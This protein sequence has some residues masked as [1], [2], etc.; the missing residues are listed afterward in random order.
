[1]P[2]S[3][4]GARDIKAAGD[5]VASGGVPQPDGTQKAVELRISL[6]ACEGMATAI[7]PGWPGRGVKPRW[8]TAAMKSGKSLEAFAITAK[9]DS[10]AIPGNEIW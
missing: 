4:A 5:Y 3:C 1:V 2:V 6:T 9:N 10:N 8:L 7:G